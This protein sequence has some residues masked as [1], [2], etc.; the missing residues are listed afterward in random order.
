M[1]LPNLPS[2]G[3]ELKKELNNK[4]P[5]LEPK[6]AKSEVA[7]LPQFSLPSLDDED[8]QFQND[9]YL[10][11]KETENNDE[12]Q[13][14]PNIEIDD[15]F[16]DPDL[17]DLEEDFEEAFYEEGFSKIDTDEEDYNSSDEEDN[18]DNL[19][20]ETLK[21]V[22]QK[23]SEEESEEQ[24]NFL[25]IVVPEEDDEDDLEELSQPE[26]ENSKSIKTNKSNQKGFKELDDEGVKEFFDNLKSKIFRKGKSAP[27]IKN[28]SKD[29]AKQPKTKSPKK[30]LNAKSLLNKTIIIYLLIIL[31][32]TGGIIFAITK[33]NESF[34]SLDK[35][36]INI[37][38][39]DTLVE[40]NEF[41]LVEGKINFTIKNN[42]DIS[43]DFLLNIEFKE[44]SLIPFMG[45]KF[46]CVSDI[47][48][49]EPDMSTNQYLTCN[50]FEDGSKYKTNVDLVKLP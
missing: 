41:N 34:N 20:E 40:L 13:S 37:E 4:Q 33:Y 10:S 39:D 31:L 25:P 15:D 42:A 43:N 2:L 30:K 3:D 9:E 24:Y 7:K 50:E 38:S 16:R 1:A 26:P 36:S 45:K 29:L 8:L 46:Q 49:L 32:I 28:K 48:A 27:K 6:T 35:I 21:K 5:S 44:K 17:E 14:L 11:S 18:L 19:L 23:E 22:E 47:I 12:D